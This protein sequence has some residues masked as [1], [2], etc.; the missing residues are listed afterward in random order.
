MGNFTTP[1]IKCHFLTTNRYYENDRE[2]LYATAKGRDY[3]LFH[4]TID[5]MGHGYKAMKLIT[6]ATHC[7]VNL[8]MRSSFQN[9]IKSSIFVWDKS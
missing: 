1:L 8:I 7:V 3:F 6:R 9:N 5:C 4:D 2:V